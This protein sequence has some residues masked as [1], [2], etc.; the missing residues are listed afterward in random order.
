MTEIVMALRVRGNIT[1]KNGCTL[2][3]CVLNN[4]A[5]KPSDIHHFQYPNKEIQLKVFI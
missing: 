5:W 2:N 3:L 1:H 4:I